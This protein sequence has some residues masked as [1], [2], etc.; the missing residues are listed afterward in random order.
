MNEFINEE[1]WWEHSQLRT[2]IDTKTGRQLWNACIASLDCHDGVVFTGAI[3]GDVKKRLSNSYDRFEKAATRWNQ[4]YQKK[5]RESCENDVNMCFSELKSIIEGWESYIKKK[6]ETSKNYQE[7]KLVFENA[8]ELKQENIQCIELEKKKFDDKMSSKKFGYVTRRKAFYD[9]VLDQVK[10]NSTRLEDLYIHGVKKAKSIMKLNNDQKYVASKFKEVT[11]DIF[12]VDGWKMFPQEALMQPAL[13][14]EKCSLYNHMVN[15]AQGYD[16]KINA[17]HQNLNANQTSAFAPHKPQV[18]PLINLQQNTNINISRQLYQPNIQR[19][20]PQVIPTQIINQQ[21][22]DNQQ[23]ANLNVNLLGNQILPQKSFR[24]PHPSL[25]IQK[26]QHLQSH[27]IV[28][29]EVRENNQTQSSISQEQQEALA[30]IPQQTQPS[31]P[32]QKV[33]SYADQKSVIPSEE[34]KIE[35]IWPKTLHSSFYKNRGQDVFRVDVSGI[36][37]KP[38]WFRAENLCMYRLMYTSDQKLY[39]IGGSSNDEYSHVYPRT[40]RV[41]IKKRNSMVI[42]QMF[43]PRANFGV[44]LSNDESKIY[45]AGGDISLEE[46]TDDVEVF[47]TLTDKWMQLPKLNQ[48]KAMVSLYCHKNEYLYWFGGYDKQNTDSP[49]FDSIERLSLKDENQK[50]ELL[51]Y[52]LPFKAASSGW[53]AIGANDVLIL[54]G[55]NG[56]NNKKICLLKLSN[57]DTGTCQ[58]AFEDRGELPIGD[59][60]EQ[61][62]IFA[63]TFDDKLVISGH[64]GVHS[65]NISTLKFESTRFR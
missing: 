15:P 16:N 33:D 31:S 21:R 52:K 61:N 50:W 55:W 11:N 14:R 49:F 35:F 63:K 32:F 53:I 64:Y 45:V 42:G 26:P 40:R 13:D 2:A 57:S 36:I 65:M 62:N 44:C 9:N 56:T 5:L 51:D 23:S 8:P 7:L 37:V 46:T 10:I 24:P 1:M 22:A 17:S 34:S 48:K 58:I 20:Q 43:T 30:P 4:I 28:N 54:G 18:A 6:T 19:V 38:Q 3:W 60:F 41:D 27:A 29:N 39:I 12:E 59:Y 47:D 25:M